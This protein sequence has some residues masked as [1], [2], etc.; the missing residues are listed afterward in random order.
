MADDINGDRRTDY[1]TH[2]EFAKRLSDITDE[3]VPK[4]PKIRLSPWKVLIVLF[5]ITIVLTILSYSISH[6]Y[7]AK[8]F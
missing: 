8:I 4:K 1:Y 2:A 3:I 7:L 6:G 5:I